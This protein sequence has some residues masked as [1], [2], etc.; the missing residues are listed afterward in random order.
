MGQ[1]SFCLP[2]DT[3]VQYFESAADWPDTIVAHFA[4]QMKNDTSPD[5]LN[6]VDI[7]SALGNQL[8]GKKTVCMRLSP[9]S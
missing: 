3:R 6:V 4:L 1:V 2:D 9:E 8:P 5:D 7:T